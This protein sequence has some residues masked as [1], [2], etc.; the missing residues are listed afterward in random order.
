MEIGALLT[1]GKNKLVFLTD[2]DDKCVVR[3]GDEAV[4]YN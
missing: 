3:F 2:E 4:A 1:E